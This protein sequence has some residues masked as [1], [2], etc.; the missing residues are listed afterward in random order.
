M[1]V[2]WKIVIYSL[3]CSKHVCIPSYVKHKT[4]FEEY[5]DVFMSIHWKMFWTPLT[6]IICTKTLFKISSEICR[7]KAVTQVWDDMRVSKWHFCFI[8]GW[9][10]PLRSA[11]THNQTQCRL[12]HTHL[13]LNNSQPIFTVYTLNIYR[14]KIQTQTNTKTVIQATLVKNKHLINTLIRPV[15]MS[16]LKM[17][18][19]WSPLQM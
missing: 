7:T 18:Q 4:H 13:T 12:N 14:G 15:Q 2:N 3:C 16:Q 19:Y 11:F 8:F 9:P 5:L 10:I 17:S 6:L 1:I